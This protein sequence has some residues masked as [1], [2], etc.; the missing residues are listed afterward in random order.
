MGE[1]MTKLLDTVRIPHRTLSRETIVEDLQW[2][3][4][5]FMEKRIPVAL[6]LKKGIVKTIQP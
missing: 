6:L 1:T 3:A 2:T 4:K 5:T